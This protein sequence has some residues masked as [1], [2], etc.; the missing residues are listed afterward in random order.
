MIKELL[1]EIKIKRAQ[2]QAIETDEGDVYKMLGF[3]GNEVYKVMITT[4]FQR[5]YLREADA[6]KG[7][8]DKQLFVALCEEED[9]SHTFLRECPTIDEA[10]QAIHKDFRFR[11]LKRDK[12]SPAELCEEEIKQCQW[13]ELKTLYKTKIGNSTYN[14]KKPTKNINGYRVKGWRVRN[15]IEVSSETFSNLEEAKQTVYN[16]YRYMNDSQT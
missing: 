1:T 6:S 5:H 15:S 3:I 7:E 8:V 10:E 11:K 13:I 4:H 2:W 12:L 16:N 14:I 9:K